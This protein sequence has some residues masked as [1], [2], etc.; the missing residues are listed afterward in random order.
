[1][2]S[3]FSG[4]KQAVNAVGG[5]DIDNPTKLYDPEYPCENERGHCPFS[6]AAGK[7][8]MNGTVALKYARCRHGSCGNDFGRAA[9]QQLLL[10]ALRQKAL[11][12]STLTNPVK[13]TGLID[14]IGGHV[15]TDLKTN[16]LQKLAKITKDLDVS[17]AVNKV[18]DNSAAG[19][20]IDGSSKFP[21]AGSI[22]IP[23]AGAFD[24][25]DI[26]ELAHSIFV[27]GYLKKEAATIQVQN[28]STRT[29][30]AA[31]VTKQLTAYGYAVIG[32][33]SADN[34][35]Y[36]GSQIIDYS[37]GT[38][39]YTVG[40]LKNRFSAAVTRGQRP[41]SSDHSATPQPDIVIIVGNSYKPSVAP[42]SR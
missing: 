32:A 28:G 17:N 4:F 25:T 27:D 40:Y 1:M 29:G 26:Q 11:E 15:R 13:L 39:P 8:H 23:K 38:K 35:N 10:A 42:S 16:E 2:N 5:V 14:S 19:L 6:L 37:G 34:S 22:L 31:A 12:V 41:A 30:L 21:G 24:Y 36:T 3:D 33:V 7:I 20:L 18:L 9:R